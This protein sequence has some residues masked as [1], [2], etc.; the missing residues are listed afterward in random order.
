M[1]AIGSNVEI[2]SAKRLSNLEAQDFLGGVC[3]NP[4]LFQGALSALVSKYTVD[5]KP[6]IVPPGP[7]G[8]AVGSAACLSGATPLSSMSLALPIAGLPSAGGQ[9][10]TVLI[11][12]NDTAAINHVITTSAINGIQGAKSTITMS[13]VASTFSAIVLVAWNGTWWIFYN[14]NCT[15]G[16]T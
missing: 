3:T 15:I 16:G 6:I 7:Q 10:G 14:Y 13:A 8:A 4:T 2:D 9:D 5:S 11:I 12:F 1:T